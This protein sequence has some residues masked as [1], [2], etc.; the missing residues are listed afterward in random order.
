MLGTPRES[1]CTVLDLWPNRRSEWITMLSQVGLGDPFTWARTP[2]QLSEGQWQRL[3]LANR[4][5]QPGTIWIDEWLSGLDRLTARAVAWTTGRMLRK[6]GRQAVFATAHD[7]L[8]DHLRPDLVVEKSWQPEPE[9]QAIAWDERST[10]PILDDITHEATNRNA[11]RSLKPLHYAA[12]DPATFAEIYAAWH[13]DIEHP[14]AVAVL[15]Y[16]DLHSSARN[17]ATQ[18]GWKID[19]NAAKARE[20]NMKWR[21]LSRIVVAPELRCI[22]VAGQLVE[23]AC[24]STPAEWIECTTA[25]GRYTRF[26]ENTGFREFPQAI[27]GTEAELQDWAVRERI[28]DRVALNPDLLPALIESMSVR[29]QREARRIIW[30]F[31]HQMALHRRTRKSKPKRI[32]DAAD[33]RWPEAFDLA[34]KRLRERP[35]YWLRQTR[36]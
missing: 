14:A 21:R 16:P 7:D 35:T 24:A 18:D 5:M 36:P 32:A 11:W 27:Q 12:G 3:D 19:G 8:I 30:H 25:L 33:P 4:L 1:A 15:S 34:S 13:P 10:C 17:I 9:Y 20:L 29:K 31:Y 22:G 28:P 2:E 6:T 23:H 26:L